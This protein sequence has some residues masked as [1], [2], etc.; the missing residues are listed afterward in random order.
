MIRNPGWCS[1]E[2]KC[3]RKNTTYTNLGDLGI[4]KWE[5]RWW[6]FL[7]IYAVPILVGVWAMIDSGGCLS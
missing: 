3:K 2:E 5:I 4:S 6:Y 7:S 1:D